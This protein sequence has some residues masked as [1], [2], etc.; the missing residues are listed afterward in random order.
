VENS[1]APPEKIEESID[2]DKPSDLMPV[3]DL[4]NWW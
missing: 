4:Q 1:K 3:N 2:N